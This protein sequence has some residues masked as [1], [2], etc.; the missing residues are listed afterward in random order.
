M[1]VAGGEKMIKVR[2]KHTGGVLHWP[3]DDYQ[4]LV[5]FLLHNRGWIHDRD[6]CVEST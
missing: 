1:V 6:Y 3:V 4:W 5:R 2:L